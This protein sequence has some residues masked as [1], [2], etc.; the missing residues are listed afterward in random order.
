MPPPPSR[1]LLEATMRVTRLALLLTVGLPGAAY[2]G[3]L[4]AQATAYIGGES[5]AP[6]RK[7]PTSLTPMR[8]L[9]RAMEH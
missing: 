5:T 8:P 7:V 2:P 6:S 4:A 3:P 9:W 1:I